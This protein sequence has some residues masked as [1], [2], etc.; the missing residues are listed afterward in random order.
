[1]SDGMEITPDPFALLPP[2]LQFAFRLQFAVAAV[3]TPQAV[4]LPGGTGEQSFLEGLNAAF[5]L[6]MAIRAAF[7]HP[8]WGQAVVRLMQADTAAP[9]AIREL[10]AALPVQITSEEVPQ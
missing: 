9:G 7:E 2:A 10:M 3:V 1:M 5:L 6:S 4:G 8:E